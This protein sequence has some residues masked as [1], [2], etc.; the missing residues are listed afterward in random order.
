MMGIGLKRPPASAINELR[1][2]TARLVQD[3]QTGE[4]MFAWMRFLQEV[5]PRLSET[6]RFRAHLLFEEFVDVIDP[7][8]DDVPTMSDQ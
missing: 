3:G 8:D 5:A 6:D 7:G 4:A 1:A 2:R